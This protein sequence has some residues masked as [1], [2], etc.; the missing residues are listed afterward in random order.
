MTPFTILT[1][2]AAIS[3]V[4][5]LLVI[6]VWIRSYY[7]SDLFWWGTYREGWFLTYGRGTASIGHSWQ[8]VPETIDEGF[9]RMVLLS[10]DAP[11]FGRPASGAR[12]WVV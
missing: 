6:A 10:H 3:S 2:A 7:A 11:E 9:H 12:E 1:A 4:I 5:C 8:P